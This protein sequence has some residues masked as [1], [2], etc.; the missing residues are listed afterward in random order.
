M[1]VD[2]A[3]VGTNLGGGTGGWGEFGHLDHGGGEVGEESVG[4]GA[5]SG[6]VRVGG[7]VAE[8]GLV[9]VKKAFVLNQVLE[10]IV[11]EQRWGFEVQRRKAAAAVGVVCGE[12]AVG[13]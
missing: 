6:D 1:S 12:W 11:V 5:V 9:G 10:E 7:G 8:E 4:I 3:A 13:S 2:F